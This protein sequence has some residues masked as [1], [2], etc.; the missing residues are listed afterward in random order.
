MTFLL[1][2][3]PYAAAALEFL[4]PLLLAIAGPPGIPPQ[5]RI[6]EQARRIAVMIA[7]CFHFGLALP[8]P[9]SSFY[10]FSASC[11]A[12][13]IVEVPAAMEAFMATVCSH[14]PTL[15]Q[16]VWMIL[17]A[18][19]V[20][21]V[22]AHAGGYVS[23]YIRDGETRIAPF[24][25]PPYDLYDAGMCWESGL[26]VFLLYL[27]AIGPGRSVDAYRR[28]SCGRTCV[29]ASGVCLFL[30][31]LIGLSP[32]LGLRTYP[33]FAMFSNLRVEGSTPNHLFLG[34][35]LDLFGFQ[36]DTV[37]VLDT[38]VPALLS[39]QV[40][41]SVLYLPKTTQYLLDAGM[42]PSLWICPPRWRYAPPA[43]FTPFSAPAVEIR[44]RLLAIEAAGGIIGNRTPTR[45]VR[46]GQELVLQGSSDLEVDC[47][48][49]LPAW[50]CEF[51]QRVTGPFRSFDE[52][53]SPCRH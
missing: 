3:S 36:R 47:A 10:P 35:G 38:D 32:Y 7:A 29:V 13:L 12:M 15:F 53:W 33:A 41:L 34:G 52:A 2:F 5:H 46:H 11:L 9:P 6:C 20:L 45:V 18:C 24:E 26:T 16:N 31:L 27:C 23:R 28:S 50:A 48:G 30:Q 49:R 14:A 43:N 19:L 4:L 8:L 22:C 21:P 1:W 40:D 17:P 25:Y 37:R 39:F 51:A 42:H 44:R